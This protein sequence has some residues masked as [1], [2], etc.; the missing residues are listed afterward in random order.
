MRCRIPLALLGL[1]LVLATLP[2][3]AHAPLGAGENGHPADATL[4]PDPLKSYVVY[5]HLHGTE[6][7]AWFRMEMARGDRLVLAVNVNRAD[8]SVPDLVVMGPGIRPS[9]TVPPSIK[10]PAGNGA[11]VIRGTPP[12]KGEYEPF[13]PSVIYETASY[14]TILGE[15]GTYYAAVLATGGEIDYSF[16]VGYKEQFTAAEW[17]LI[18]FSLLGI[19]LWEGQP[20]WAV[21]AP[22]ILVILAGLGILAWQQER[23]RKKRAIQEWVATVAGLLYLGTGAS[24]LYQMIRALSLTGYTPEYVVT[25]AFAIIPV[26]LGIWILGLGRPGLPDTRRRRLSLAIAGVLGLVA[27]AGLLFGPALALVAAI[28]PGGK[29]EKERP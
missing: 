28:L 1:L 6:E 21:A 26:L 23:D 17:L 11:L 8:S 3:S 24:T 20:A 10:V 4:I 14:N 12:G 18:P 19:Y 16:V 29:G 27:W 9:G 15:P 13:S 7:A 25:L 5:G 2:A 22:Y